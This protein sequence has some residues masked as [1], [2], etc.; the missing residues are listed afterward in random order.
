MQS[1]FLACIV[2]LA[3]SA[4]AAHFRKE[5][6]EPAQVPVPVTDLMTS[7]PQTATDLQQEVPA[8]QVVSD[9]TQYPSIATMQ[10]VTQP[11]ASENSHSQQ[12]VLPAVAG[13]VQPMASGLPMPGQAAAAPHLA[14]IAA[15]A[16]PQAGAKNVT[17]IAFGQITDLGTEFHQLREDDQ[18][19]VKQLGVDIKLRERLEQ[20]LHA[21]EERLEHDNTELAQET[22]SIVTA[23]SA[24]VASPQNSTIEP[25]PPALVQAKSTKMK[26]ASDQIAMATAQDVKTLDAD[27]S[28]LH[29]RDVNEVKALR[30][31]AETRSALSS[32]I[33]KEREE[34]MANSETLADNLGQIRDLVA[35]SSTAAAPSPSQ[36]DATIN[37]SGASPSSEALVQQD[38][39]AAQE[40]TQAAVAT[41]APEAATEGTWLR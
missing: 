9:A 10:V 13:A 12:A 14:P 27:I 28:S 7:Q 18:A 33:L 22:G 8:T 11:A 37:S 30:G 21:E 5:Q 15:R 4:S 40:N 38:A 39:P 29:A 32:Q 2:I 25:A 35:P 34:L 31:N 41:T 17:K 16:V 36:A 26:A 19:H 1:A 23:P 20:Q 3:S 24:D 6:E